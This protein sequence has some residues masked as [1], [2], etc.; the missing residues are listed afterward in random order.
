MGVR[1]RM[2]KKK[3]LFLIIII[4][5]TSVFFIITAVIKKGTS[6]NTVKITISGL[7]YASYSLYND[8]EVEISNGYGNN[9]IVI[10]NGMVFISE[11]D[12]PDK[13][14]VKHKPI[15]KS[16]ESII[17]LP[18]KLVVEITGENDVVDDISG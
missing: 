13:Y 7:E 2:F 6:P 11:A 14:C 4:M 17:C 8:R 15:S 9:K 1:Q 3:D 18:H 10:N 5:I 16:G 12:C